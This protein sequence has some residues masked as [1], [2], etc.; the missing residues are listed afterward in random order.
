[1]AAPIYLDHNATTPVHP[2]VREAMLPWLGDRWGNP[3]SGHAYG[4]GAADVVSRA[5]EQVAALI[6]ARPDE[7][8]FT[9]GGTEADNLAVLGVGPERGGRLVSTPI[10]HPAVELPARAL[11]R[12]REWAYTELPIDREG[13]VD[14]KRARPRIADPAPGRC[15][16]V[17]VI[18]AQNETGVIQPVA[19]IAALARAASRGV[20][21]HSDAA[22]AVGKIPVD[23]GELGVDLL[24]VVSHKLYGPKGIGALFIRAGVQPPR[25]FL[26]GGGQERGV[27]PGT[28][29]VALIVGLG[30]ACEVAARDMSEESERQQALRERLWALLAAEIPGI[31]RT[32]A[33]ASTLPNT[34]HVRFPGCR[35]ADVL[36][37]ATAVAASTGSACHASE[38]GAKSVLGAM[39]V[40]PADARGSVR[41]S[42][43]R[44]TREWDIGPAARALIAAWRSL[45]ASRGLA[46]V[47]PHAP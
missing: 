26:L 4:R 43:G 31:Q 2:E 36:A 47:H 8:L 3:S 37:R 22:Q 41:L 21:V 20:V 27:R 1:M 35:G 7:I 5:R 10:E 28:E 6:G 15:D 44:L 24:T 39:G 13:R 32:G 14:L 17:S 18:L 33:G 9:S 23:V 30:R 16:L 46:L 11:V 45:D 19:E 38:P 12:A 34:L 29:P 40:A 25:P 42:L